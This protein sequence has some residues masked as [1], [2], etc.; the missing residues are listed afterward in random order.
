MTWTPL[1]RRQSAELNFRVIF[2]IRAHAYYFD[3]YIDQIQ[4]F[5]TGNVA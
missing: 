4:L 2:S 5:C 3:Y 1:L